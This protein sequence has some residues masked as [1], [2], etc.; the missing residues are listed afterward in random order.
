MLAQEIIR[1]KRDGLT[2]S[3]E[4]IASFVRALGDETLSEAQ[5]AAF[6]MAVFF[7]G[8]DEAETVA[9]T[10][11]MR[12]SG[13]V[14]SWPGIDR[15]IADKHSTGG[16]GDNVSLMLA[17][18]AAAAGLAV[19]MISG[20]GL[21]PS[22]GTLDK[23]ESIPGYNIG[24]D[25]ATLRR[26]INETGCA[27]IGQTA[28]LAPADK[29]LYAI[30]DVTATVESMPLIVSSILSKKLAAGL[31]TLVLDVKFGNGA[32]MTDPDDARA[33]ARLLV[34]VANGA[35]LATTALV[36]DMNEPL[37]DAVGNAV[38]IENALSFLRGEKA[39]TRLEAVVFAF[40]SEMIANA[41]LAE[42]HDRAR[43][44][45]VETV[46]GGRA[47]E[48]FGRMVA[49]LGGPADFVERWESYLPKAAIIRPVEAPSSGYL[50][51][52]DAR[53][54]GLSVVSLGGGRQRP[55]DRIDHSVGYS[56]LRPLGAKV[57]A[58]EPLALVHAATEEGWQEAAATL[59]AAIAIEDNPP[60]DRPLVLD[61][62]DVSDSDL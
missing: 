10:L 36:T 31:Q 6:A 27:I 61:R 32:F 19:P 5:A 44:I 24:P 55:T 16:I 8:M 11:A 47:M 20:R 52:C 9:L 14:L 58:G 56:V 15:P 35:G 25:E 59:R 33:L 12:D 40:A 3:G 46:S 37:A 48:T 18:I 43:E 45:A 1:R 62:V 22:G 42:S 17:P 13:H 28:E 26:I 57:A 39:G 7:H 23:L 2:L 51:A 30:R 49:G 50:A 41:G 54:I 60:A 21:G 34:R 53:A 4:E 29:R 38:E